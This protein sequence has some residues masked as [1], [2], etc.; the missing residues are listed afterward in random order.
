L[1]Q[2]VAGFCFHEVT[3]DPRSTGFQ[4][5]GAVP[6]TLTR[7]V[8]T[9]HLDAIADSPWSPRRVT[10]LA[11]TPSPRCLLLTFDDGGRSALDAADELSRRGWRG[12]FFIV[13]GRVGAPTFLGAAEIRYLHECGHVIGSHSHTHPDIFR[14]LS[15]GAMREEWSTS[16]ALL[17]DWLGTPCE[18]ASVPGGEISPAVLESGAA[19]G[20]RFLFTVEPRVRPWN[21][22]ECRVFGR[23]MV[24]VG[25]PPSRVGRLAQFRGWTGALA[26]RR[27]KAV[28]RR[29]VP[30]LYRYVVAQ[31]GREA[32]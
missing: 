7:R 9:N 30:P 12:H 5:P 29:S 23:Y 24:K 25:T 20:F 17:S 3:E 16:A 28:A 11:D 10:E 1:S 27:L 19:V 6:F 4:R 2:E 13:T 31:R 18:A 22:R 26:V 14:E 21:V 32:C 8:F 15:P